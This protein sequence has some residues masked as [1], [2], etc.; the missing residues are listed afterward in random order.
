[1]NIPCIKWCWW[2][3]KIKIGNLPS[4]ITVWETPAKVIG[5]RVISFRENGRKILRNNDYKQMF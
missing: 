2:R 4:V 3:D 5:Y 1:M